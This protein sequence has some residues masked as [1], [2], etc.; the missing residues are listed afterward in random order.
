MELIQDLAKTLGTSVVL[1]THNLGIL[2]RYANKINVMYAGHLIESGNTDEIFYNPKHPYTKGLLK[3][4]PN[5]EGKRAE[6]LESIKGQPPSLYQEPLSCPFA[7]R[8]SETM[9]RCLEENPVLVNRGN[10][11]KVACWWNSDLKLDS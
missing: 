3:T 9:E 11:H 5:L 4:L 6:R 10:N 7:P 1:I 8:C 2:A